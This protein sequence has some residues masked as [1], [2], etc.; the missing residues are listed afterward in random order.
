LRSYSVCPVARSCA[1][2]SSALFVDLFESEE[3]TL[4]VATSTAPAT[5]GSDPGINSGGKTHVSKK[6]I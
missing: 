6:N 1:A 4:T 3:T 2:R 5:T